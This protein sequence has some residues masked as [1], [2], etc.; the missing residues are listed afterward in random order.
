MVATEKVLERS[1]KLLSLQPTDIFH[2]SARTFSFKNQ[3][4]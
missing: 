1:G 3:F 2:G 4:L